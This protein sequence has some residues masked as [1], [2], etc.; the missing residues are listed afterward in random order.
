LTICELG[1]RCQS[2]DREAGKVS[3]DPANAGERLRAAAGE[4]SMRE[5]IFAMNSKSLF[6]AAQAHH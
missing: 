3:F 1:L 5:N 4:A 2:F 6:E